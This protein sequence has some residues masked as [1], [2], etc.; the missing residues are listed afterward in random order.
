MSLKQ[1]FYLYSSLFS[2]DSYSC[3]RKSRHGCRHSLTTTIMN[4][5]NL[6]ESLT[7]SPI[8]PRFYSIA[9]L[10]MPHWANMRK[11]YNYLF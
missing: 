10:F 11:R 9:A 5:M 1:V 6:Y 7:I 8:R 2:V 4:S 3:D